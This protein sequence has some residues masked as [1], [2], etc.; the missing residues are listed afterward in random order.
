MD[1]ISEKEQTRR[2]FIKTGAAIVTGIVTASIAKYV[3]ESAEYKRMFRN[4]EQYPNIVFIDCHDLGDWLGCYGKKFLRTPN[5]DSLASEGA[6]FTNYYATAPIC[7]PSRASIYAGLMPHSAGTYGQDPLDSDQLCM[8]KR[9][10]QNGYDTYMC[11]SLKIRNDIQWAGYQHKLPMSPASESTPEFF[12]ERADN[13]GPPF[14]AHFSFGD[15]HRPYLDTYDP[16]VAEQIDVPPTMP[17]IDIV[18][19]DL[20]CLCY[21]VEALDA[22]V[23]VILDSIKR[24]GLDQNTIVIFTTDHGA[25]LA[26]AKHTLYDPGIRTSLV[27][28]YPTVI[29]QG[30]QYDELLSNLD[31]LPTLLDIS[32]LPKPDRL[33]GRSFCS[34]LTGDVFT[35][36][37]EVYSEHTWG[38]RAGLWNYSPRRSVRTRRYKHIHNFTRVPNY[39]DTGWLGRFGSDRSLPERLY[40][41]PAPEREL[42]DLQQDPHE[43]NNLAYDSDYSKTCQELH[44]RLFAFLVETEDAI[45]NG[46]VPNKEVFPDVPLWEDQMDGSYKLRRYI[47][48][49]GSDV[50]FGEPLQKKL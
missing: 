29:E 42:Y 40:G 27:M 6:I 21:K 12:R 39:I 44:D 17:D 50:P 34:L 20:A 31:L 33:Q 36:R 16:E 47:R 24:S 37:S 22:H 3:L 10:A 18:R 23:G 4:N 26:R 8:A 32:G 46:F 30:C 2:D 41:A 45:L 49:E 28:K 25:A 1:N 11:G 19:K 7:M 35:K 14:M 5:I 15:V 13:S 43:L 9:F 38:R 48:E